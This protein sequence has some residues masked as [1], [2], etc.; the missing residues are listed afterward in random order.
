MSRGIRVP[1][2][3]TISFTSVKLELNVITFIVTYVEYPKCMRGN[4]EPV[5]IE[6]GFVNVFD[7]ARN[8]YHRVSVL[9][10]VETWCS[11]TAINDDSESTVLT[12]YCYDIIV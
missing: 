2:T 8:Q 9:N 10:T 12:R 6:N 11:V 4:Y 7:G 5:S 3:T 1:R